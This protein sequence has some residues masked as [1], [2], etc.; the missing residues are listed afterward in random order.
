MPGAPAAPAPTPAA[1]PAP[2]GLRITKHAE[3]V[4]ATP[5]EGS[6]AEAPPKPPFPLPR[7]PMAARAEKPKSQLVKTLTTIGTVIVVLFG[8]GA[9]GFKWYKRIRTV[10]NVTAGLSEDGEKGDAAFEGGPKNLWYDKCAMLFIKHTNHLAVAEACRIYWKEKL[11]KQLTSINTQD[12]AEEAGEF[13]LISSH[14]GWVRLL[15]T[16][17]WPVPQHEALAQ[18]LSEKFGTMIF[19]FRTESFADTYHFG[20]FD[21]GKKKFHAQMDIIFRKVKGEGSVPDEIVTTTGDEF[22]KA[23]GYKP[24]KD[25][26]FDVF[27][28]DKITQ[29]LGMKLWDEKDGT[30]L[31]G[32]VLKETGPAM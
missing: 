11:H 21:Q 22:A 29:R 2:G 12:T 6:D 18:Y 31:K 25:H 30:E 17:E 8:I 26:E 27:D 23:N 13:E 1:A 4:A 3:P 9:F 14:N 19:E 20:V 7:S 28:A 10:V 32:T 15:G 5:T 16:Q 24:K